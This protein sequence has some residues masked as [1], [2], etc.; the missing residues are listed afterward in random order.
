MG[1][2]VVQQYATLGP[3]DF[4]NIVEAPNNE[5][6]SRVSV[7]LCSRGTVEI[8]TL[9]AIPVNS[10]IDSLKK[11]KKGTAKKPKKAK[12]AKKSR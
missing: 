9:A 7:E 12:A 6:I 5:T 1:A 2:R 10:F 8:M 11:R 4:M 3:F